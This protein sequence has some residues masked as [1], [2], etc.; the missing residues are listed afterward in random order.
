M[1]VKENREEIYITNSEGDTYLFE[2]RET[3]GLVSLS[4][5]DRFNI[6]V[7]KDDAFEMIDSLT[8]VLAEMRMA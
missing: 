4:F 3:R 6:T 7:T 1:G 8:L 5:G 2:V